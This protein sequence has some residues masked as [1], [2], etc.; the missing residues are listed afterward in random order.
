MFN[1]ITLLHQK[2]ARISEYKLSYTKGQ[3]QFITAGN[4]H[5]FLFQKADLV[6]TELVNPDMRESDLL[7]LC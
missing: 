5:I 2:R 6:K 3:R 7:D 4:S 1:V